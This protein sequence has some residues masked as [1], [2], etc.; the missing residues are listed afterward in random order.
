MSTA[1]AIIATLI[2][3][4]LA[5]LQALLFTGAPLGRFA[6]GGRHRV[7]PM[8]LRITSLGSIPLYAAMAFVLLDR[9]GMI[10]VLADDTAVILAWVL[11]GYFVI[12]S[13]MNFMSRSRSERRLMTPVALLLDRRREL[14]CG[15]TRSCLSA[16]R[17]PPRRC[18]R[19][20]TPPYSPDQFQSAEPRTCRMACRGRYRR[21]H[22][23]P[24]ARRL[25]RRPGQGA[26]SSCDLRLVSCDRA[27]NRTRRHQP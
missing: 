8:R 15:D 26:R 22:K 2:L 12:G 17:P 21:R 24:V 13:V 3:V 25:N 11:T 14:T 4:C 5:L 6:W 1:V 27:R 9:A 7:L 20:K 18:S 19:L 23:V 16:I 10:S